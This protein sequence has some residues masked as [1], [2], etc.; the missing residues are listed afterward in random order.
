M[1]L[2][3]CPECN[4]DISDKARACPHCGFPITQNNKPLVLN[5]K[6]GTLSISEAIG[7]VELLAKCCKAYLPEQII[8]DLEKACDEKAKKRWA[9]KNGTELF[10]IFTVDNLA[11]ISDKPQE[12]YIALKDYM[13]RL[14]H[15]SEIYKR[16]YANRPSEEV[17]RIRG[18]WKYILDTAFSEIKPKES[19]YFGPIEMCKYLNDK[20]NLGNIMDSVVDFINENF[21]FS[22]CE[23]C[24]DGNVPVYRIMVKMSDGRHFRYRTRYYVD[25]NEKIDQTYAKEFLTTPNK[26]INECLAYV[27]TERKKPQNKASGLGAT[28]EQMQQAKERLLLYVSTYKEKEE[29]DKERK[30]ALKDL[31]QTPVYTFPNQVNGVKCPNC[32]RE[33]VRKITAGKRAV[34]VGMFGLFSSKIGKTMECTLCGY[35]W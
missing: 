23:C 8:S 25:K 15:L 4:N 18:C 13:L 5:T 7:A 9:E 31:L 32:G 27:E 12:D 26:I 1:A 11:M 19:D 28:M 35:K 34:S 3:K 22:N 30:N 2:I 10:N 14:K 33:A 6:G 17:L 21:F 29:F 20:Y 24:N 16:H